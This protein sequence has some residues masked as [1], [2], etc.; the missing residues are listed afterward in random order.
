M[1]KI[2][3]LTALLMVLGFQSGGAVVGDSVAVL[4]RGAKIDIITTQTTMVPDSVWEQ[5]SGD[6]YKICL[7]QFAYNKSAYILVKPY[8]FPDSASYALP[9]DYYFWIGCTK[10][11]IASRT[12]RDIQLVRFGEAH[13]LGLCEGVGEICFAKTT[14][15]SIW[16]FPNATTYDTLVLSY[17]AT[18]SRQ[19]SSDSVMYIDKIYTPIMKDYLLHRYYSKMPNPQL[20]SHH[21]TLF[22]GRLRQITA[23]RL[24]VIYDYEIEKPKVFPK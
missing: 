3:V 9:A 8:V 5:W 15:D 1:K 10:V 19:L 6:A 12:K 22:E 18:D 20:S 23:E 21:L 7:S 2:L 16:F 13:E 17:F 24:Q 14:Q 4:I 11:T